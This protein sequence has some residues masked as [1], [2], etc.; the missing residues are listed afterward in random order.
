LCPLNHLNYVS[1]EA[2]TYPSITC[3]SVKAIYSRPCKGVPEEGKALPDSNIK[4]P[5]RV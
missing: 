4:I 3:N 1:S 5:F 2:A